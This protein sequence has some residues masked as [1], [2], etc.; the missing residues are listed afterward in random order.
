MR[1]GSRGHVLSRDDV[2]S[3]QSVRVGG[4]TAGVE[5]GLSADDALVRSGQA[6]LLEAA[7]RSVS[8]R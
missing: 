6:V 4:E 5:G 8:C 1:V 3:G 7:V 2:R